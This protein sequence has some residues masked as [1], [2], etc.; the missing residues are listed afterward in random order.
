MRIIL[1]LCVL[2]SACANKDL[3][4]IIHD[5][6]STPQCNTDNIFLSPQDTK[7]TLVAKVVILNS[8]LDECDDTETITD[9]KVESYKDL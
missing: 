4:S 3:K 1:I 2:L 6:D 9:Q 5:F 8:K 7:K